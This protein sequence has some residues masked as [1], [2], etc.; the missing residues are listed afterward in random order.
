[1]NHGYDMQYWTKVTNTKLLEKFKGAYVLSRGF[2]IE[3]LEHPT[4]GDHACVYAR[5]GDNVYNTHDHDIPEK[6]LI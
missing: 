3:F 5:V 2:E 4:Q 1:M 6:D